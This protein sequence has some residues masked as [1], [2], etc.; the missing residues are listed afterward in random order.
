[1][2]KRAVSAL[3]SLYLQPETQNIC[4]KNKEYEEK[5]ITDHRHRLFDDNAGTGYL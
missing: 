2:K 5:L 4:L 1:M 3:F